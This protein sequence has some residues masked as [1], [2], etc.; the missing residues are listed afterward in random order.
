MV[1]TA[2]AA[3]TLGLVIALSVRSDSQISAYVVFMLLVM[4]GLSGCLVPRAFL[5][6]DMQTLSLVTPHA[7]A[8][9]GFE[10]ILK[11][12]APNLATLARCWSAL[13]GF[14]AL[15]FLLG[16]T[17]FHKRLISS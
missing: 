16:T 13:A 3:T 14:S 11:D 8:L 6:D 10:E 4:G 9:I 2:L 7:W 1:L 12:S 15:F 5:P 17:L